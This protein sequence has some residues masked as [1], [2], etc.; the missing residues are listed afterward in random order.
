[1]FVKGQKIVCIDDV[2]TD[3]VRKLY[4]RLPVKDV[5]YTVREVYLGR[6][7][8]LA[9]DS[10]KMDG[11]IGILLV[12]IVNPGDPA[13]QQGIH[14]ELGFKGERFAPLETLPD[15][16]SSEDKKDK[17]WEEIEAERYAQ[18]PETELVPQ[19]VRKSSP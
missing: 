14:G 10:G 13:L 19:P 7:N 12:E 17:T 2:F 6:G 18:H 5:V 9:K 1:M 3:A 16:E 15:E 4:R 11:E 8:V